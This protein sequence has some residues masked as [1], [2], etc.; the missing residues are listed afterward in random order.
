MYRV[1]KEEIRKGSRGILME[2]DDDEDEEEQQNNN[3]GTIMEM[4]EFELLKNIK[5]SKKIYRKHATEVR[6]FS[7]LWTILFLV[8]TDL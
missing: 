3:E 6:N 4:E 2:E 5:E 7:L 1:R 8:L